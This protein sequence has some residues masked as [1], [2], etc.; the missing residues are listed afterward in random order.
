MYNKG[1]IKMVDLHMHTKNSD[2]TDN[3]KNLLKLCEE[4]K[5]EIISI[6]DHD[7]CKSYV[8]MQK[9]DWRNIYSGKIIPGCEITTS[10]KGRIVEILGYGV[11]PEVINE[12]MLNYYTHKLDT[13]GTQKNPC[14]S[15]LY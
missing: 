7:T 4:K 10:Y 11:E 15:F 5:I 6:T 2:G 12:Y 9:L 1:E 14:P 3:V 8:D 13:L